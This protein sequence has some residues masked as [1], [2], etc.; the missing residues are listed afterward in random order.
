[1]VQH[2]SKQRKDVNGHQLHT[3]LSRAAANVQTNNIFL[4]NFEKSVSKNANRPAIT[5]PTVSTSFMVAPDVNYSDQDA[6]EHLHQTRIL[7]S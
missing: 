1:L 2:L 7:I 6:H 4:I 3:Q 5:C